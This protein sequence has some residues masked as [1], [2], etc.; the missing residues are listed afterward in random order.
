[1]YEVKTNP[2]KYFE[3]AKTR[4]EIVPRRGQRIGRI[5][6][7]ERAAEMEKLNAFDELMQ[8][9]KETLSTP[10]NKVYDADKEERLKERGLL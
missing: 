5:I 4:E 2:A 1:M 10:D 7:E 6:S 9:A 8:Y 3:L